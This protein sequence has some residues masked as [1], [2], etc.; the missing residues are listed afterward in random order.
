MKIAIDRT[1]GVV[2]VRVDEPKLLYPM[3]TDFAESVS[4]IIAA[5]EPRVVIDSRLT[6]YTQHLSQRDVKAK[7]LDPLTRLQRLDRREL[8]RQGM[9]ALT[10]TLRLPVLLR[11]IQGLSYQ[12]IATRIGLPEGTVKSRINRGRIQLAR[13]IRKLDREQSAAA[14]A[15]AETA[16]TTGAQE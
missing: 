14:D 6:P 15:Q 7:G 3:L 9:L 5:G 12:E 16:A 1:R 13:H 10:E 4:S 11:D 8:L 2:I